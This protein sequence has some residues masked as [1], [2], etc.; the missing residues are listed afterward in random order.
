MSKSKQSKKQAGT[1]HGVTSQKIIVLIVTGVRI[2]NLTWKIEVC[3]LLSVRVPVF[4]IV[5]H[6]KELSSV[7]DSGMYPER[8]KAESKMK[9]DETG[10]RSG[11]L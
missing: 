3:V 6:G 4:R 8:N 7:V 2:S 1:L 9:I 5:I 11:T 10:K